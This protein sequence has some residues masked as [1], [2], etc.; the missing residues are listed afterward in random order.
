MEN[1]KEGTVSAL[2]DIL[3]LHNDR[4]K[5]YQMAMDDTDDADLKALFAKY[6]E[7]SVTFKSDLSAAIERAGG[8]VPDDTT[9]LGQVHKAW[10]ELKAAVTNRD[11]LAVLNSCEQ[12][13]DAIKAAYEEALE[14]D[15]KVF[16][17]V[18]TTLD[19]QYT[20]IKAAHDR[21]RALRNAA[22]V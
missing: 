11:R 22:T 13:E 1:V 12:G 6:S 8:E 14:P 7:Q 15:S 2:T 19:Q 17:S 9:F 4:I 18:R 20:E 3:K 5:G 16:M 10:M 21:I